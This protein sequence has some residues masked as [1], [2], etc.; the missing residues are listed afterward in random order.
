LNELGET[1]N[2]PL[3]LGLVKLIIEPEATS[4]EQARPLIRRSQQENV[5]GISDQE[6][7]DL[8]A[9]I[10]VY[11]STSLNWKEIRTMLGLDIIKHSRAYQEAVEEGRQEGR[12]EIVENLLK[13]RFGSLDEELTSVVQSVVNLTA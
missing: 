2:L 13:V 5:T 4:P 9:T 10:V 11:Q 12:Q 3:A 1:A 6:I 8:I 7:I